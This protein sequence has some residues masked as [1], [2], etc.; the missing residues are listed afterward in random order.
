MQRASIT[1]LDTSLLTGTVS[2]FIAPT[3]SDSYGGE[4][5]GRSAGS[6]IYSSSFA[7]VVRDFQNKVT[8]QIPSALCD[9]CSLSVPVS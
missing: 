8:M 7:S 3:L 1:R 5:T 4:N 6:T 9:N 2:V